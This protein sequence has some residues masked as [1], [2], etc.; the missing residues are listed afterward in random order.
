MSYY[1]NKCG[2][3]IQDGDLFC[4]VCGTP[5][6]PELLQQAAPPYPEQPGYQP[7]AYSQ[8]YSEQ[9]F[10]Q[11]QQPYQQPYYQQSYQ[12]PYYPQQPY[13]QSQYQAP[14]Y[15]AFYPSQTPSEPPA[16][17]SPRR[18]SVFKRAWF[19]VLICLIVAI[20]II[21]PWKG[22]EGPSATPSAQSSSKTE[23]SSHSS[24]PREESKPESSAYP[25]EEES[26]YEADSS[27]VSPSESSA[28]PAAESSFIEEESSTV[29]EE[30]LPDIPEYTIDESRYGYWGSRLSDEA[31]RAYAQMV[32][33]FDE[34]KTVLTIYQVDPYEVEKAF[35]AVWEDYPEYFWLTGA[36]SWE[37]RKTDSLTTVTFTATSLAS[38]EELGAMRS[39]VAAICRSLADQTL[40]MNAYETALFFHDYIITTTEYDYDL[41]D[42]VEITDFSTTDSPSGNAYGCLVNHLAVCEGYSR[43]FQWLLR[44]RGF[45]CLHVQGRDIEDSPDDLSHVWNLAF[46]DGN[47]YYVDLT[48]DD[49]PDPVGN[50]GVVHDFFCITTD[51]LLQT[52]VLET[53]DL[54]YCSSEDFDYYRNSGLY[55]GSYDYQLVS[56]ALWRQ[57]G[58]PDGLFCLKFDSYE[59]CSQA[60]EEL[61]D[62]QKFWEI[63]G[64]T[65]SLL[66]RT[67][68]NGRILTI[69][70]TG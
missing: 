44:E 64:T 61:F 68:Q 56:D 52:H 43:A 31:K 9:P 28:D 36:F 33:E 42:Y 12:E 46:L 34:Q 48:W 67:S 20:V 22:K 65:D 66:Y 24:R 23:S 51:E 50:P 69:Q 38:E 19:W 37:S 29:Q 27:A 60:M 26:S 32:I 25:A 39:E 5:V 35:T 30:S 18:K 49:Q 10:Y 2:S 8:P 57:M 58:S 15:Q 59:A 40:E 21:I 41:L 4:R 47:G 1:C 55:V 16:P 62:N 54:P 45:D 6:P 17:P 53:E 7:P 3:V 63:T 13:Q 14:E 70:L 11:Q